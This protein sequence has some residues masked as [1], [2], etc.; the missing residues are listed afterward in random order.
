[1]DSVRDYVAN[2]GHLTLVYDVGIRSDMKVLFVSATPATSVWFTEDCGTR[3]FGVLQ[4]PFT[5]E[6]LFRFAVERLE[7]ETTPNRAD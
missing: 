1:M 7:L 2:G 5:R 4:K 6:A 3:T